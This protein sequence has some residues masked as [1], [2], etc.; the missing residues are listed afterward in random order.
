[1]SPPPVL[2]DGSTLG[3]TAEDLVRAGRT[4][5]ARFFRRFG[6][7]GVHI[8]AALSR[9]QPESPAHPGPHASMIALFP[10]SSCRSGNVLLEELAARGVCV[11]HVVRTP[12]RM[13]RNLVLD[14]RDRELVVEDS[15]SR[16]ASEADYDLRPLADL[17]CLLVS[18]G[19]HRA[20]LRR[21]AAAAAEHRVH[22]SWR[23]SYPR[24]NQGNLL[25]ELGPGAEL[26]QLPVGEAAECAGLQTGTE[27]GA[28][29]A[30]LQELTAARSVIVTCGPA[31]AVGRDPRGRLARCPTPNW[32]A[33]SADATD[34]RFFALVNRA[35]WTAEKSLADALHWAAVNLS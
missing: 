23:P 20:V 31:G 30:A 14:F 8:C 1:L 9:P 11:D 29:A 22:W 5:A 3:C 28:V 32:G 24:G 21:A 7:A 10:V 12:G 35:L 13:M 4:R 6:G 33:P 2:D 26:L 17:E 18:G 27:P 25:K 16:T 19:L 15:A 34:A